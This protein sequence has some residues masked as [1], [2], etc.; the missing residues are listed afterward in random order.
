[1]SQPRAVAPSHR[2][3]RHPAAG[4]PDRV[5]EPDLVEGR[6]SVGPDADS[7]PARGVGAALE[8]RDVMATALQC[9][10]RRETRNARTD[11]KESA[12]APPVERSASA[13]R[14]YRSNTNSVLVAVATT[15]P[16]ASVTTPSA[17]PT[18]DPAF[19]TVPV[20]VSTPLFSRTAFR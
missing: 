15:A 20:A 5:A 14:A 10:G 17:K 19:T 2:S 6:K 11:D 12:A 7:G 13:S 8:D 4:L 18:R 9:D 1:M 3:G 16:A